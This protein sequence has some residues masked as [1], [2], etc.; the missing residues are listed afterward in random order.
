MDDFLELAPQLVVS[1]FPLVLFFYGW[2]RWFIWIE[3]KIGCARPLPGPDLPE[4]RSRCG[5]P[6]E[7]C[8]R[9]EQFDAEEATEERTGPAMGPY[10]SGPDEELV[11]SHPVADLP[12]GSPSTI[13][14]QLTYSELVD[15]VMLMEEKKKLSRAERQALLD[16]IL[17]P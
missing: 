12:E 14:V 2:Y 6:C 10:R 4:R 8:A 15:F 16:R 9:M 1:A 11:D 7:W 13:Q 3:E 5:A 17:G